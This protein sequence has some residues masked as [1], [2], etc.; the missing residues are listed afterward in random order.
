M[1]VGGMPMLADGVDGAVAGK[2]QTP[3]TRTITLI[4]LV[5]VGGWSLGWVSRA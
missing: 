4:I 3:T 1:M 5:V 2:L